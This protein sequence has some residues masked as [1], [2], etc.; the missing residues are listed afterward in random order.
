M[1]LLKLRTEKG[2]TQKDVAKYLDC[3]ETV[4]ARYEREER[5]P[6]F[7][8][9]IKLAEYFNT[10]IDY[11]LGVEGALRHPITQRE[12]ELLRLFEKEA[13]SDFELRMIDASRRA[14][15]RAREDALATLLAHEVP[16][17]KE[18]LA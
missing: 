6:S 13:L 16:D 2:T 7:D 5:A 11:L 18:H 3:N 10:T 9:L 8:T 12:L 1:N 14:D 4:Y 15:Q 17:K